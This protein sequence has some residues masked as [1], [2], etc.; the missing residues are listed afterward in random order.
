MWMCTLSLEPCSGLTFLIVYT[1]SFFLLDSWC[2]HRI[3]KSE[4]LFCDQTRKKLGK[5]KQTFIIVLNI[6]FFL[7][8]WMSYPFWCYLVISRWLET[9]NGL[10]AN[11]YLGHTYISTLWVQVFNALYPRPCIIVLFCSFPLLFPILRVLMLVCTIFFCKALH[12]YKKILFF[13]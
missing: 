2:L 11:C 5:I 6:L 8:F 7:I 4:S 10:N 9:S 3:V 1:F 13:I 12:W